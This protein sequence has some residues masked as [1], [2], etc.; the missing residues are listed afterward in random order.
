M[1][2]SDGETTRTGPPRPPP[3]PDRA[4]ARSLP[5]PWM[6]RPA[7][8][9]TR[10]AIVGHRDRRTPPFRR[11]PGVTAH[12]R[13]NSK[14]PRLGVCRRCLSAPR[15]VPCRGGKN[16]AGKIST[17]R[18]SRQEQSD[19]RGV[20]SNCIE[21]AASVSERGLPNGYNRS[22]IDPRLL[23]SL[24]PP[25]RAAGGPAFLAVAR[26]GIGRADAGRLGF[27]GPRRR[28]GGCGL[29][30]V[31]Q[32]A[33]DQRRP[34]GLVAGAEAA[35][36]VA[37]EV[38][39]EQDQVAPVRVVGVAAVV[40]VAGPP[41]ARVGQEEPRSAGATARCAT[42]LQVHHRARAGRALDLAARRRRSGGTAPAPRS[43]GS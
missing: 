23:P 11:R 35:A 9:Y 18:R 27:Q 14:A 21:R 39:V 22:E 36:V 41:A 16:G 38:F 7:A 3:F 5:R 32:E 43:A 1:S 17:A 4:T 19:T 2:M 8:G 12:L 29:A 33:G 26:G 37:V 24:H 6:P 20:Y 31:A 34:A 15:A 40:A 28:C 30:E 25:R 42:S 13:F 10:M